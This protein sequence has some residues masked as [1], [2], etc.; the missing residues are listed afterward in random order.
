MRR[1]VRQ[2]QLTAPAVEAATAREYP[3]QPGPLPA[4]FNPQELARRVPGS[5]TGEAAGA[6]PP[7]EV[8]RAVIDRHPARRRRASKGA[9]LLVVANPGHG[10]FV[11]VLIGPVSLHCVAHAD[12]PVVVLRGPGVTPLRRPR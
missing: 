7:A 11:G 4:D 10:E 12:C 9:S 8:R 6:T 3:G 1:A 2:A 5:A